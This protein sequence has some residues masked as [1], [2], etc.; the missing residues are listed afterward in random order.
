MVRPLFLAGAVLLLASV[1]SAQ[2]ASLDY[3]VI[4]DAGENAESATYS[5]EL[6]SSVVSGIPDQS[7]DHYIITGSM[8]DQEEATTG[9][10]DVWMLY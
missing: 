2:S 5:L 10:H 1:A 6:S 3:V 7:S 9:H 4:S 8:D